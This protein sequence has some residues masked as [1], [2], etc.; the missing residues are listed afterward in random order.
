MG[1]QADPEALKCSAMLLCNLLHNYPLIFLELKDFCLTPNWLVSKT[2][3]YRTL[4]YFKLCLVMF[5]IF[6]ASYSKQRIDEDF[7]RPIL[8]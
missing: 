8:L 1:A 5:G 4:N 7:K 3:G 2:A 6:V